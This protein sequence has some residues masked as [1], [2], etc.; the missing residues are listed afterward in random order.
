MNKDNRWC[1]YSAITFSSGRI[2]WKTLFID[3]L[4]IVEEQK[5]IEK[6]H[7]GSLNHWVGCLVHITVQ[8]WYDPKYLPCVSVYIWMSQ[9]NMIFLISDMTCNITCTI[10]MNLSCTQ[11]RNFSKQMKSHIN[12]SSKQEMH[13]STK[14]MNTPTFSIHIVMQIIP[15][16]NLI[17]AQSHQ[18]FISPMVPSM[19]GV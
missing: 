4:F 17:Y 8:T 5:Q 6:S 7:E 15:E 18:Q 12:V 13:K 16:I 19:P 2:I 14:I 11:E 9:N 1:K 10:H 3:T